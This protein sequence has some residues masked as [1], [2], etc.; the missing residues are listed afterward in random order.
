MGHSN[1]LP[2]S[3]DS[4][5]AELITVLA[6]HPAG[7]RR[8]SV[9]RAIRRRRQAAARDIPFKLEA[10]VERTFRLFCA[11][12]GARAPGTARFSR[13]RDAVGEVWALNQAYT[14]AEA[15]E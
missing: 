6:P 1:D 4:L 11:P 10:D 3:Q 5:V 14:P 12:D 9:M 15:A 8:W 2:D 13:P 7:L